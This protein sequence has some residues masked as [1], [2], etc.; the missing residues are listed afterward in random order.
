MVI[1]NENAMKRRE[2]KQIRAFIMQNV[3]DYPGDIAAVTANAFGLSRQ[4]V[5]AHLKALVD[6]GSLVAAGRTRG[7]TY[8]PRLIT[9]ASFESAVADSLAEDAVWR[10]EIREHVRDLADN[11][12]DICHHGFTEI[13]NNVIDHAEARTVRVEVKVTTAFVEISVYD[14]GVGIFHKIAT[15]LALED[16][17]HAVLELVKGKVTTDPDRHTGEGIFFT[18]RMFTE[19]SILSGG[20]FFIHETDDDD[21][22]L[23]NREGAARGTAVTMRIAPWSE[24]TAQEV[25]DQFA[26]EEDD[27]AFSRTHVPVKLL[28]HMDEKLVSRSQAKRLVARFDRFKEVLLDFEGVPTVGQ[29]FADEVFRVYVRQNPDV[30]IKWANASEAVERAI[31]RATAHR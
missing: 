24:Q 29:A 10:T 23:E 31:K 9:Q 3:E 14:D 11:V 7:K 20:L 17:R 22:L 4:A 13:F 12:R 16:E 30:I 8:R 18:S 26:A 21:W 19:F 2:T 5:N 1:V 27:Y 28:V 6:N 15:T 25:F